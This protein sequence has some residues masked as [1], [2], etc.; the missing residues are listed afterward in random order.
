[1]RD[2]VEDPIR[3]KSKVVVSDILLDWMC[4]LLMVYGF[5]LQTKDDC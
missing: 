1:V 4:H 3:S 5:R 2:N